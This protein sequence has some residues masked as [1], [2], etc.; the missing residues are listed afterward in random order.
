MTTSSLTRPDQPSEILAP[1]S[2]ARKR[3]GGKIGHLLTPANVKKAQAALDAQR[4]EISAAVEALVRE[5]EDAVRHR[6]VGARDIIWQ[7]AH[8][9]RGLAG[10]AGKK[11]LGEAANLMCTYLYGTD[12]SFEPD[13]NLVSTIAVVALEASRDGADGDPMI[14][15]LLA[16]S[17]EAVTAQRR[18]EDRA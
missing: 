13:A 10:N 11:S 16:E 18:R 5:L 2:N 7:K 1:V 6:Q 4:P 14:H 3:V 12:S 15:M 17:V 9:I 8:D